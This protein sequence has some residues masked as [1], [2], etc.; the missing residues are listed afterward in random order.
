MKK[1]IL[2]LLPILEEQT[3]EILKEATDNPE[4]FLNNPTGVYSHIALETLE[5]EGLPLPPHIREDMIPSKPEY[6]IIVESFRGGHPV[7]MALSSVAVMADEIRDDKTR[8][9]RLLSAL[10]DAFESLGYARS[11]N[12]TLPVFQEV[13]EIL[14]SSR[15]SKSEDAGKL[16]LAKFASLGGRALADKRQPIIDYCRTLYSEQP[17]DKKHQTKLKAIR[18]RVLEFSNGKGQRLSHDQFIKTASGW[19]EDLRT[20]T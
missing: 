13:A 20:D 12:Q 11:A 19:V 6:D 15:P 3:L 14:L 16:I 17:A 4:V 10:C 2:S 8:E 5:K 18:D 1:T 7:A 9:G